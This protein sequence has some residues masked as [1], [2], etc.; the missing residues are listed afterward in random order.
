MSKGGKNFSF[1][2]SFYFF[3]KNPLHTLY[4]EKKYFQTNLFITNYLQKIL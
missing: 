1:S 3:Q 2:F 4:K